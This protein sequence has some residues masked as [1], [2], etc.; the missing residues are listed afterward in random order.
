MCT[1]T[2]M[3]NG[4]VCIHTNKEQCEDDDEL[5][6]SV[7]KDVLCHGAGDERFVATIWL[8]LQQRLCWRLCCQ[9]KGCKSVHNQVHPQHLHCLQGGVLGK[10]KGTWNKDL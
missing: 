8:P 4:N 9:G 5:I 3:L 6:D 7:P 1:T 10:C 2:S